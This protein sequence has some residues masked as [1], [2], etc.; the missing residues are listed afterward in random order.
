MKII[1]S[2]PL[3]LSI[4]LATVMCPS[5]A[6]AGDFGFVDKH[7]QRM[8]INDVV[9]IYKN[10]NEVE[11]YALPYRISSS[12]RSQ[13]A[14][15]PNDFLDQ[16]LLAEMGQDPVGKTLR[17]SPYVRLHIVLTS[18]KK[19]RHFD[20]NEHGIAQYP[21]NL[22]WSSDGVEKSDQFILHQF[23]PKVGGKLSFQF[24][25]APPARVSTDGLKWHLIL[26]HSCNKSR[27]VFFNR[28]MPV[29][30]SNLL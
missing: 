11:I 6:H 18:D 12:E 17:L 5:I 21:D 14:K 23:E 24:T 29:R 9:G 2:I 30:K 26:L 16:K 13:F 3:F 27:G 7:G 19:I 1:K 15:N 22:S 8:I 28:Q 25:G 10:N 4:T 20:L